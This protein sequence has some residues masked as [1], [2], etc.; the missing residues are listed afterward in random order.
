MAG[1]PSCHNE[2]DAENIAS[3][4]VAVCK[5]CNGV[6]LTKGDLDR[7]TGLELE[8]K[9]DGWVTRP[10][11]CRYC[12]VSIGMSPRCVKC[13]EYPA[14]DC[15]R[16]HGTMQTA[17]LQFGDHAF[18]VDRCTTCS[19]V[20]LDGDE[21]RNLHDAPG[22]PRKVYSA[23]P[24]IPPSE[25][26]YNTER[27]VEV[28]RELQRRQNRYANPMLGGGGHKLPYDQPIVLLVIGF[29]FSVL[30]LSFFLVL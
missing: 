17:L 27:T 2:F 16:G 15:P 5:A 21:R 9:L 20:W 3:T 12:R 24:S 8:D 26:S 28:L 23:V 18:E 10:T 22:P 11:D 6:W 30:V 4:T 25:R 7:V 19:G 29:I 14:L 13:G 1:C